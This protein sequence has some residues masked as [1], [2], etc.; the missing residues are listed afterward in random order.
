M[1]HAHWYRR[2][3][4][5]ALVPAFLLAGCGGEGESGGAEARGL[6]WSQLTRQEFDG[7]PPEGRVHNAEAPI[8]SQCYTRTEGKHNPCYT[9]H[10]SYPYGDRPNVMND[11]YLQGEYDFSDVGM[12]NHWDNLFVDRRDAVAAIPDEAV[13]DYVH[14]DNYA[15][16]RRAYQAG[17]TDWEGYFPIIEDLASGAEAFDDQGF[18]RDGSGWV[19]FNYKPLP[20]TFW[21]TNGSTDDVMIRLPEAFRTARQCS[22]VGETASRDVYLA[23]LSIAEMAIKGL[24][25]IDTPPIDE[26]AVCDDLDGDGDIAGTVTGIQWRDHYVGGAHETA[27]ARQLYPKGTEFLHTVRYVGVNAEGDIYNAPRMKEVRYMRKHRFYDEAALRSKYGNEHQ[28][29]IDGNLPRY[30]GMDE[31]GLNNGFGWQV[32]GFIEDAGGEL[33]PQTHEEHK[34]CMGCHTTIGATIDQ[35]FAFGRKVTGAEGWGYIDTR[36]MADAP[37]LSEDKGEI[38]QYLARVGG[39]NEF[40]ENDE[41][42]ARWF[43][44]DGNVRTEKVREADVYE[45]ITPSRER[46]LKLNKAYWLITKAQSF[47]HGRDAT[48]APAEN[49]YEEI[50]DDIP[51]LDPEYRH[52]GDDA[53]DMR[54]DWSAVE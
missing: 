32:L 28:E 47:T 11:G 13:V 30:H 46:A 31:G 42:Q 5:S 41:M 21:P 53:W 6:D 26:A 9:C 38:L 12:T 45:L 4:G 14:E 34:F 49:V 15:P 16:F 22:S 43:D 10:Q 40:R 20:S 44:E 37:S 24:D 2:M 39:G 50:P 18:A 51:P 36:G 48:I 7:P 33:R 17:E 27:T 8:T 23:N 3:L 25:R 52:F 35:T 29:K 54:L 1:H 19:A